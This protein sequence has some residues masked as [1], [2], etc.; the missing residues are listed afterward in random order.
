VSW[1]LS[2]STRQKRSNAALETCLLILFRNARDLELQLHELKKLR[3]QVWEA[4]LSARK[5]RRI[6]NGIRER[7]GKRPRPLC[8][9]R[10][11]PAALAD[12]FSAAGPHTSRARG[13]TRIGGLSMS[14]G[15]AAGL[16]RHVIFQIRTE[17]FIL[18]VLGPQRSEISISASQ[19]TDRSTFCPMPGG[20]FQAASDA[21]P[22]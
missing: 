19:A 10:P 18:G 16:R 8:S 17:R 7:L 13:Q 12:A 6:D 2:M 5:S 11:E 22:H 14:H 20:R 3:Y 21:P 9:I 4:E 15:E 1:G